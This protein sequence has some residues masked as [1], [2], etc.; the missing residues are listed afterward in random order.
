[1]SVKS[2]LP[3][4]SEARK[5]IPL[6][7]GVIAYF[8]LALAAVAR[9]SKRGND[10]H[11]PGQPLHWDRAKSMDQEDCIARHLVD[12]N[13]LTDGEY[14]DAAAL[15]WRA[16]AKLQLLEEVRLGKDVGSPVP[17]KDPVAPS[18]GEQEG[19][20]FDFNDA[21]GPVPAHKHANGGGWVADTA[22]VAAT[23]Y[24]GPN[25]RVYGNVQVSGDARVYG[26][27]RVSGDARVSDY[28]RVFDYARVYGR[29]EVSGRA[30]VFG[31]AMVSDNARVCD[32][33]NVSGDA[34][35]YGRARVSGNAWVCK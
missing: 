31:R 25:A 30:M 28:A 16:L 13:L 22:T 27:A 17:V 23:A 35:V 26:R 32:N 21:K 19:V 1:M 5:Q 10:K 4:D 6:Y 20:F 29:A 33:A 18:G 11:N 34:D 24:V 15:A 7:S 12:I 8:P 3:T 14:E 9:V 2:I